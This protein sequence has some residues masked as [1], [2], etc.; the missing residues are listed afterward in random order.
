MNTGIEGENHWRIHEVSILKETCANRQF[1]VAQNPAHLAQKT[2]RS[3]SI[4]RTL[5]TGG[6][7][8]LRQS[9]LTFL[10][11][12]KPHSRANASQ[13]LVLGI[14]CPPAWAEIASGKRLRNDRA[15]SKR[16]RK[17]SGGMGGAK[18]IC[19]SLKQGDA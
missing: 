6:P 11:W 8:Y 15:G 10:R 19:I 18:R 5:W 1:Q 14:H 4:W 7:S 3:T 12:L 16:G 9:G 2:A 13:F 17:L